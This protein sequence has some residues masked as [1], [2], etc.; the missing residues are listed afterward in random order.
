VKSIYLPVKGPSFVSNFFYSF[1]LHAVILLLIL[2][3]PIYRGGAGSGSSGEYSI[4]LSSEE[5]AV[6]GGAPR[7]AVAAEPEMTAET[8]GRSTETAG[9]YAGKTAPVVDKETAALSQPDGKLAE[10]PALKEPPPEASPDRIDASPVPEGKEEK[11]EAQE[12]GK[13]AQ[14]ASPGEEEKGQRADTPDNLT[15]TAV[16]DP[17]E[18]KGAEPVGM[19]EPGKMK[20][21]SNGQ[22]PLAKDNK[23]MM[24]AEVRQSEKAEDPAKKEMPV[25]AIKQKEP[26]KEEKALEKQ[27]PGKPGGERHNDLKQKAEVN[28]PLTLPEV[29]QAI[30]EVPAPPAQKA[31][32]PR[33]TDVIAAAEPNLP[34]PE[35]FALPDLPAAQGVTSVMT[36]AIPPE[37]AAPQVIEIDKAV[38][39]PVVQ[40]KS[41]EKN[42]DPKADLVLA[43]QDAEKEGKDVQLKSVAKTGESLL[44]RNG[45]SGEAEEGLL[46]EKGASLHKK[47]QSLVSGNEKMSAVKASDTVVSDTPASSIPGSSGKE[48]ESGQKK[49]AGGNKAA[50]SDATQTG[51][52]GGTH[53][54]RSK[55]ARGVTAKVLEAGSQKTGTALSAHGGENDSSLRLGESESGR[56]RATLQLGGRLPGQSEA[57]MGGVAAGSPLAGAEN[58]LLIPRAAGQ[59][60]GEAEG[61]GPDTLSLAQSAKDRTTGPEPVVLADLEEAEKKMIGVPVSEALI[62]KDIRI[63]VLLEAADM[64]F[65]LTRLVKKPHDEQRRRRDR[66]KQETVEGTIETTTAK[67]QDKTEAKRLFAV[68]KAEKA[69]YTF[70][71]ENRGD[72]SCAVDVSIRL[73]EG[74]QKERFKEYKKRE[75][76]PGGMVKFKFIMPEAFFW[77]DDDR[78]SGSA[79]DSRTVTKF[80]YESGLIWKEEKGY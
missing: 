38:S 24:T 79:E 12:N 73:Y 39:P 50:V 66:E 45:E 54:G 60:H 51:E 55:K 27:S 75:I 11:R 42:D 36:L 14:P 71:L 17:G 9:D 43:K 61:R 80:H 68:I 49:N 37:K 23:A 20:D 21:V 26:V 4:F 30:K 29:R 32:S 3:M 67:D 48:K 58:R 63:E 35:E 31:I 18:I 47:D 76:S 28:R 62:Q 74:R 59:G 7:R 65:V 34:V 64:P 33:Q 41:I 72:K 77:D 1:L 2:S 8:K 69:V 53:K 16:E 25:P 57:E 52:S 15:L 70:V 5:S 13:I 78:F 40:A 44:K 46:K 19:K 6:T 10:A 56:N 22:A